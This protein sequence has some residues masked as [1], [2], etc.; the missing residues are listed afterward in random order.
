MRKS[1]LLTTIALVTLAAPGALAQGCQEALITAPIAGGEMKTLLRLHD[2]K[3]LVEVGRLE[4]GGSDTPFLL[5]MGFPEPGTGL[6][7]VEAYFYARGAAPVAQVDSLR[8]IAPDGQH[9]DRGAKVLNL[10]SR[11]GRAGIAGS[12]PIVTE[13]EPTRPLAR[14]LEAGGAFRFQRRRGETVLAETVLQVPA[15]AVRIALHQKTLAE[16]R[17]RLKTCPPVLIPQESAP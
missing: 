11:S 13:M 10:K 9:W 7:W 3:P 12:F 14:M 4:L 5:N 15:S 16:A 8:I 6:P 17:T 1:I 2:G